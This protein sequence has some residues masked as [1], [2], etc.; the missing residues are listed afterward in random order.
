MIHSLRIRALFKALIMLGSAFYT[1]LMSNELLM[2]GDDPTSVDAKLA[3][4][5]SA[6]EI[7]LL[8]VPYPTLYRRNVD[9][10][11]L[12]KVACVYKIASDQG[13]TFDKFFDVLRNADIQQ[14]TEGPPRSVDLRVGII[15]R[16]SGE[17]LSEFY[18]D[19]WGG[20]SKVY[21]SWDGHPI[22]ASA[23]LP[24]QLRVLLLRARS[25]D[26]AGCSP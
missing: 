14:Y 17:V 22:V 19:D 5:K 6:T 23:D 18:S 9:K 24:N 25:P 12:Q 26:E 13:P 15:F 11:R 10:I 16:R 4:L 1:L 2:A 7:T 21:G 20:T 8:I 3:E